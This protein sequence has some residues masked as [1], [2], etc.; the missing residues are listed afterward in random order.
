MIRPSSLHHRDQSVLDQIYRHPVAHNLLWKDVLR[1]VD[2][3]GKSEQKHDGKWQ[4]EVEG[5]QRT[6]PNPHGD[7]ID[8]GEVAK[9]REFLDEAGFLHNAR[10]QRDLGADRVVLVK[11][12][13]IDHHAAS[14]YDLRDGA[15]THV[16][17]VRPHDPHHFLHH[18][19]HR[20]QSRL[21]GQRASEDPGFYDSLI[22]ALQGAGVAVLIGTATG[23]SAALQVL[24]AWLRAE[25]GRAPPQII[26]ITHTNTSA[27][28][29]PELAK[30]AHEALRERVRDTNADAQ[31]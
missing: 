28:T 16:A 26:E 8:P 1:L 31:P 9:L 17:T 19:A 24:G 23:S 27:Y 4:F 30:L 13:L 29:L 7:H 25:H 22:S 15:C 2:H 11:M 10:D 20:D 5:L 12:V 6:F 18:L 14:V 3:L 21:Q